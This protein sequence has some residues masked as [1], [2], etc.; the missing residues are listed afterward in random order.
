MN[1][2][3]EF[4]PHRPP[5]LFVDRLVSADEHKTVGERT[6]P[7]D[8]WFFAGHFPGHPVVPGVILVESLAQCGG[9]GL[10]AV[11]LFKQEVF[12][13]VGVQGAKFRRQ[14][15]PGEL[16]RMEVDNLKVSHRLVKQGGRAW[17]GQELAAEAEWICVPGKPGA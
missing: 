7:A 3:T 9:A 5:F 14:V 13:L 11:G 15:R 2:I 8:T 10:V 12:L 17:V 6:W 4:I 1:D 16:V